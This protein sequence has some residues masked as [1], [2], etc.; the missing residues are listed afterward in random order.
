MDD[1][2]QHTLGYSTRAALVKLRDDI[3][4]VIDEHKRK[5]KSGYLF[6]FAFFFIIM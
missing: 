1:S 6:T 5:N 4:T 3:R 2:N